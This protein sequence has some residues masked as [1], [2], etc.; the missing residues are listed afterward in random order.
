MSVLKCGW[1]QLRWDDDITEMGQHLHRGDS[2]CY[3]HQMS[4]STIKWNYFLCNNA[5]STSTWELNQIW[6]LLFTQKSRDNFLGAT[7]IECFEFLSKILPSWDI[8]QSCGESQFFDTGMIL[9]FVAVLQ[10]L[11]DSHQHIPHI[12]NVILLTDRYVTN[13][14][15]KLVYIIR[16]IQCM[17]QNISLL[18]WPA[19]S[20]TPLETQSP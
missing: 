4:S 10:Y 12:N 17:K 1:Y 20:I 5:I 2:K 16:K 15:K 19:S 7:Y 11:Q 3:H 18:S 9:S 8:Q 14:H 13:K 6:T